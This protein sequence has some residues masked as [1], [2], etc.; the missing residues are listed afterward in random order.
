MGGV[1]SKH[2]AL[3]TQIALGRR[4]PAHGPADF[5]RIG[6]LFPVLSP[7]DLL[8]LTWVRGLRGLLV[9]GPRAVP[10]A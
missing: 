8:M 6:S 10:V 3:E 7:E 5:P 2:A 9:D 4:G 1:R